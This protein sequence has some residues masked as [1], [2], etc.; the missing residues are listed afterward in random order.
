MEEITLSSCAKTN[1]CSP[2]NPYA[3]T[4]TTHTHAYHGL[5]KSAVGAPRSAGRR[6]ARV[7]D[8]D[9]LAAHVFVAALPPIVRDMH[10]MRKAIEFMRMGREAGSSTAHKVVFFIE[11]EARAHLALGAL[12]TRTRSRPHA[13]ALANQSWKGKP[14]G[15]GY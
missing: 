13:N 2:A 8:C 10:L 11:F 14:M 5:C 3:R 6:V 1:E 15:S 12:E 4:H 7:V 9:A